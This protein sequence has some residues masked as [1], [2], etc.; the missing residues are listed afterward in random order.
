[1]KIVRIVISWGGFGDA[2]MVTPSLKAIKKKRPTCRIIV[3]CPQ[4][5]IP[6]FKRNPYIDLL[7]PLYYFKK[8]LL[9]PAYIL[10]RKTF[11]HTDLSQYP[12]EKVSSVSIKKTLGEFL[13][14]RVG[15]DALEVHLT[16]KED[17]WAIQFLS[18]YAKKKVVIHITSDHSP[19][20]HWDIRKWNQLVANHPDIIFIQLGYEKEEKVEGSVDL[21][22]K[23]TL[24][25]AMS[26]IKHSDSFVGIESFF[27][28]VTNAFN[29]KGVVLFMDSS[30]MLWGHENNI[31]I[32]KNLDCSPCF[33]TLNGYKCP[34]GQE[35]SEHTVEEVSDSLI[36]QLAA[37]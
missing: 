12:L 14:V 15:N 19:N 36:K 2:L 23:T 11:K 35:C 22:G 9:S 4:K 33:V 31:N 3:Y 26:I 6:L 17:N 25:Q 13:G 21:R 37:K 34:Y 30:P 28:H 27:A 20:S 32:Y 1:M 10:H 24:R 5:H 7:V 8:P 29:K 16:R 18:K